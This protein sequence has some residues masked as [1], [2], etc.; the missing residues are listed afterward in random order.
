MHDCGKLGGALVVSTA[1]Q[2]YGLKRREHL[3]APYIELWDIR[4]VEPNWD[5]PWLIWA[6]E[7]YLLDRQRDFIVLV[8]PATSKART[9]EASDE[10]QRVVSDCVADFRAPVLPRPQVG[11][12]PPHRYSSGLEGLLQLVDPM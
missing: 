5:D 10:H 1:K 9:G 3:T 11:R 8:A 12:I 6:P 7:P 4:V 2:I